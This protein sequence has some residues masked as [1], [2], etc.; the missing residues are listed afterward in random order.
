MN[1]AQT[2]LECLRL[3]LDC[4][5][6]GEIAGGHGV[7]LA[8][9]FAAFVIDD[10]VLRRGVLVDVSDTETGKMVTLRS[11]GVEHRVEFSK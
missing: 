4:M 5:G 10:R 2:R 7:A 8:I 3:A 9:E 6:K 11:K 1:D